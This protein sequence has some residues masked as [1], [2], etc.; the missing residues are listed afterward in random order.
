MLYGSQ[1]LPSVRDAR[2]SGGGYSVVG[3][4]HTALKDADVLCSSLNEDEQAF[5]DFV[6]C[7]RGGHSD[8]APEGFGKDLF[9][10]SL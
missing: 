7:A 10:E 1:T 2:S 3:Y 4:A 8:P 9:P 5:L 6:C